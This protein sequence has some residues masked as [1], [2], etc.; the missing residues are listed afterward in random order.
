M[1]SL[2]VLVYFVTLKDIYWVYIFLGLFK[3]VGVIIKNVNK[4]ILQMLTYSF[5]CQTLIVYFLF[6]KH[7][8]N[9]GDT[10]ISKTHRYPKNGIG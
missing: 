6:G 10:R 3:K 4:G 7:G 5:I 1:D 8:V 9:S 2:T